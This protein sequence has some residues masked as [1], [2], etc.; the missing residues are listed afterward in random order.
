MIPNSAPVDPISSTTTLSGLFDLTVRRPNSS[1]TIATGDG[2]KVLLRP[3]GASSR[4]RT[5]QTSCPD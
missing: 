4:V 2:V 3:T 1:A 5:R